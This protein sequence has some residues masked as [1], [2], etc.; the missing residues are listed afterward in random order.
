MSKRRRRLIAIVIGLIGLAMLIYYYY[1]MMVIRAYV[2]MFKALHL[3][4][5]QESHIVVPHPLRT[6]T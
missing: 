2:G 5:V 3:G 4:P 1:A 6:L